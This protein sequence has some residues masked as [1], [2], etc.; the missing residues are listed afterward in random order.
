MYQFELVARKLP[1]H[2]RLSTV[3]QLIILQDVS[4][5]KVSIRTNRH[6]QPWKLH[7]NLALHWPMYLASEADFLY[8][9][10]EGW[11]GLILNSHMKNWEHTHICSPKAIVLVHTSCS[12]LYTC[13]VVMVP[14][15]SFLISSAASLLLLRTMQYSTSSITSSSRGSQNL[16]HELQFWRMERTDTQLT[17][18]SYLDTNC[19]WVWN[20]WP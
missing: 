9:C 7:T 3:Q 14:R 2:T 11:G 18:A 19:I 1:Q 13:S 4:V 10:V 17:L 12:W 20:I 6:P 15:G 16:L 5:T 8:E